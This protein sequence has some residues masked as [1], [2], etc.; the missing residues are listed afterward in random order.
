[1]LPDDFVLFS[2]LGKGAVRNEVIVGVLGD[3]LMMC[4]EH[5]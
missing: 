3:F 5:S 1:M 4:H 2:P